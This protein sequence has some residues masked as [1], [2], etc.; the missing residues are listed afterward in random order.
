MKISWVEN[1]GLIFME[2]G[3]KVGRFKNKVLSATCINIMA[4]FVQVARHIEG[5]EIHLQD[6]DV[7]EHI[8]IIG[9]KTQNKHLSLLYRRLF[10][11]LEASKDVEAKPIAKSSS[12]KFSSILD[13][14]GM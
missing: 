9:E 6:K 3:M 13:R 14:I 8:A 5:E 7:L 11:E 4:K 12:W 10:E 2:N 1:R